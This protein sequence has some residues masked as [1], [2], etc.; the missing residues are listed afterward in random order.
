MLRD[1]LTSAAQRTPDAVALVDDSARLSYR[2]LHADAL[3][4][5]RLLRRGGVERGDRVVV[6][7]SNTAATAIGFWAVVLSGGVFV[8][9]NA[10]TPAERLEWLVADS[11]AVAVIADRS[12]ADVVG[13]IG[14]SDVCTLVIDGSTREPQ[15]GDRA[16]PA[17]DVEQPEELPVPTPTDLAGLI[18]TSG[19]T[20][21]PKAVMVTHANV[22]AA[23]TA[24]SGYLG[25]VGDDRILCLSPLS[26]DYGLYQMIMSARVGAR[27]VLERSFHL[28][29]E[30]LNTIARERVTVL[31]GV[32]TLFAM[33]A[34]LGRLERWDLSSLR[35]ITS[36]AAALG[37]EQIDWLRRTF[38]AAQLFSMY[39]LTECKRCTYLPPADLDRKPGSVG[40]AIPGTEIWVVDE[41]GERVGPGVI[42][43]L[44]VRGPTVMAGYWRRPVETA[45]R[46]RP[47]PIPGE[48]VLY[49]GDLCRIDDEGY[50]YF[51]A[52]TDD[53]IK[54]RGEK[55][56]PAEVEAALR[57]L[58]RV[59]DAAVVGVPDA[60]LG[61]AIKAFVI[62][63]SGAAV[64]P[65]TLRAGCRERLEPFKVPQTVELVQELPH[66][67]NGKI[68]KA[69]LV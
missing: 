24:I 60:V 38:P 2:G 29:G 58:P 5:A 17:G 54:S 46:L 15:L 6:V 14:R 11:G 32:P 7:G 22:D 61:Q 50:L 20:A 28:P 62:V 59:L 47:G 21:E 67:A 45:E 57:A 18:Y 64:S 40:I 25:L 13:M 10:G 39:G 27:L 34:R 63:E 4:V 65:A 55:V 42:G 30:T 16:A 69:A 66:T 51:V 49:T 37:A 1:Y 53:V 43:Q 9:V 3:A 48:V 41:E 44:V 12:R 26:F 23:A 8:M 19:S 31:P 36:T 52:R 33:L 68:E 56:A 35:L